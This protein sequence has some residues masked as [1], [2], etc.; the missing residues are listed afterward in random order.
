MKIKPYHYAL[1][2]TLTG[3]CFSCQEKTTYVNWPDYL[4]GSDRNHYTTLNQINKENLHLLKPTW[5]YKTPDSGQ[6]Q[7][8]PLV[9]DGVVYGVSAS[10]QAFALDGATG[11]E[12]WRFGDPLKVWYGTSRGVA[13]WS[14]KGQERIFFTSGSL[15]YALDAQTGNPI[16]S[17]GTG[18]HI[19]L[20][21][22]LPPGAQ[23][24]FMSSTTPGTIFKDL[25][26]M[27]V[28]VSEDAQAA[29]G[30]IRAFDVRTGKLVWTFRT[31]PQAGDFGYETW[32]TP[33]PRDSGKVGAAN[34][35]AG[36]ALDTEN[37]ILF[38]PTGSA[39]PDFYGGDRPGD[40]LFANSLLALNPRTGKRLWHYQFTH[41]DVWDRDLP[42]PPNLITITRQGKKIPA[43]AQITK[44]GYVFVFERLN[45]NPLFP[46]E[47]IAVPESNI[48]GEKTASTQPVPLLPKPFA[49][50]VQ[51]LT[52]D[53]LSP[54]SPNIKE[55]RSRF[56]KARKGLYEPPGTDEVLLLP[57]YD[58]GAE[59]GGAAADIVEGIL[60]VNANEMAWF[61]Q[62]EAQIN[63]SSE[64][65]QGENSYNLHCAVCHQTDLSGLPAS[66]FPALKNLNKKLSLSEVKLLINNGK[67][68]MPGFSHLPE[69]DR[70]A[71]VNYLMETEK[72]EITATADSSLYLPP[73]RHKGYEKFL[74]ANGL[75]AIQPP[76]GTLH[77][78]DL[79]TGKYN[80][81]ITLG[82]TPQL[83]EKGYPPT[84]TENYGGPLVTQNG[85]LMIAATKD[86]YFRIFDKSNGKLLW[87][88]ELPA[89]SFATP[90]TYA[91][92]GK[93]YIVLAC[94]GEK[95]G[96]PK[97]N[98]I[99]AFA[100]EN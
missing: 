17:F 100:I 58:G 4:G 62:L 64:Q 2:L 98:V 28:R 96:T 99:M 21:T 9:I 45:G 5:V 79:N 25:I 55:L 31:L 44:Q 7:M 43:V 1:L 41:H 42:A 61:L 37:E 97:G 81:S 90:S 92:N 29:P 86:G 65:S 8:N 77:A 49:R 22:G 68:M 46:I 18:G 13:Y 93:Q 54:Y 89:A 24:K 69:K 83:K 27:P 74:D 40:N 84:G 88:Y 3:L 47:E 73:F 6:M 38:V 12:I 11:K 60:Y 19:D 36:M 14:D 39:A 52:E 33:H 94:G 70:D 72:T 48:P 34:N 56:N 76:W 26:I 53:S 59:W 50:Q 71:I 32:E 35:W 75:P 87:E 16:K 51:F 82:D 78:I 80:W 66:G 10:L 91:I 57:G 85:L 95:L 15:L 63:L 20:R 30:D 67:G 23:N